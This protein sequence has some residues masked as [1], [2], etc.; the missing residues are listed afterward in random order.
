MTSIG[1][2]FEWYDFQAEAWRPFDGHVIDS[3]V[4]RLPR[5][6]AELSKDL[7]GIWFMC[8][9]SFPELRDGERRRHWTLC[10]EVE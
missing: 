1:K 2:Q 4:K 3:P 10:R 9:L 6:S 5:M 8:W 7:D